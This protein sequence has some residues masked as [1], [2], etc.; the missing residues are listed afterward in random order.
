MASHI[1]VNAENTDNIYK[2]DIPV[3]VSWWNGSPREDCFPWG[4]AIWDPFHHVTPTRMSYLF[5]YTKQFTIL[6]R[7]VFYF[8]L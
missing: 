7:W 8:F 3:G 1:H 2:Y 5:Y 4:Q 6:T